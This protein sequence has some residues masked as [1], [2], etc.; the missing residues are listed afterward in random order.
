MKDSMPSKETLDLS[1]PEGRKALELVGMRGMPE[2]IGPYR[3][4]GELGRGGMGVIFVAEDTRLERSVAIKLLPDGLAEDPVALPQFEREAKLLASLNHPNIA[5]IFSLE[6]IDGFRFFTLELIPGDTLGQRFGRGPMD[7]AEILPLFRQIALGLEAAHQN[8]IVHCDL[9]PDNI[10]VTPDGL[11]KVLDFGIARVL[12]AR[13]SR[14][15]ASN[16]AEN[17]DAENNDAE[18]SVVGTPGYMSPE[19]LRGEPMD[20]G[21]DIWAFGCLLFE[22]L[23][24]KAA[25]VRRSL[26][27]TVEA[28]LSEDS[29]ESSAGSSLP[30][31]LS[32]RLRGIVERCLVRDRARRLGTITEA[33]QALDQE[34]ASPAPSKT[35]YF[36]DIEEAIADVMTR[37]LTV[38]DKAPPFLLRNARGDFVDS[39]R[40][41]T[42]GPL[43]VSFYRGKW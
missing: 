21:T 39:D 41:L 29:V 36:D 15:P 34:L 22:A 38:G 16:D 25:F 18:N 3:I 8:D 20:A 37:A 27:E 4:E 6:H 42:R 14:G 17:N 5:T 40:L 31:G 13:Q 43:V 33:R 11:V 26:G 24:G 2:V 7:L 9:K 12:G 28:T 35:R 10:K 30:A 1:T 19:Q 23:T 32:K